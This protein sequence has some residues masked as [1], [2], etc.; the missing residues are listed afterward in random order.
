MTC[1][2]TRIEL[3]ND[4]TTSVT[5]TVEPTPDS[6]AIIYF[7]SPG[8]GID[9]QANLDS[10]GQ[11]TIS[12]SAVTADTNS[13]WDGTLQV[14][15]NSSVTVGVQVVDSSSA[16]NVGVTISDSG[17]TYCAPS[18]GGGGDPG[19]PGVEYV[20]G[21]KS[22]LAEIKQQA[23]H[24][25]FIG[26][27]IS[28]N[29]VT[30]FTTLFH[31]ALFEWRPDAWKGAWFN[32]TAGG[33][34]M[35]VSASPGS[36]TSTINRPGGGTGYSEDPDQGGDGYPPGNPYETSVYSKTRTSNTDGTHDWSIQFQYKYLSDSKVARSAGYPSTEDPEEK[37]FYARWPEGSYIFR[38]SDDDQTL[39]RSG[40][41]IRMAAQMI[42]HGISGYATEMK[43][44]L[45]Y[46]STSG[47]AVQVA[48][49]ADTDFDDGTGYWSSVISRSYDLT[50]DVARL[51]GNFG[52]LQVK[53][54]NSSGDN[55]T[56]ES[57]F[58][59][60]SDP[61]LEISY[62]G[63]GGWRTRNH[64]PG[65][66]RIEYVNNPD[67]PQEF[68]Q[69]DFW[70]YTSEALGG[71]MAA[72]GTTHAHVFIGMNDISGAEARSGADTLDSLKDMLSNMETERPGIKFVILTLYDC[73]SDV[74]N[75]R[76]QK[77]TFNDG[78]KALA[79]QRDN[80]VVVDLAGYIE[81]QFAEGLPTPQDA[82]SS[83]WLFDGVHPNQAGAAAMSSFVW[84]RVAESTGGVVSVQG[85][86]GQVILTASDFPPV[87]GSYTGMIETAADKTYT[88]DPGAVSRRS[89]TGFYI[90]SGSGTCTANL[91]VGG[92]VVST[93]SVST[94]SGD[95]TPLANTAVL[96][97]GVIT[98]VISSN[99]SA[100]DVTFSVEYAS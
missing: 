82:F 10:N 33:A 3:S 2:P 95:Q 97:D 58:W 75:Q 73:D 64:L 34:G 31:G 8:L 92:A 37:T 43:S 91:K 90:K 38:E 42:G 85:Q 14:G 25:S 61:G 57:V 40:T 62:F 76:Q 93:A 77:D 50:A 52:T 89:I 56:I 13:I 49:Y 99:S 68:S 12:V 24:V 17:V 5:F 26:D 60:T 22:I 100:T 67:T 39:G 21:D 45:Y 70:R 47:G 84:S 54:R 78:V 36:A 83:A 9:T 32:M 88:I 87:P 86:T 11:A 98:L 79:S 44:R 23:A 59:G 96:V 29:G 28:N 41:S 18:G 27:S 35:Q 46:T 81:D 65:G 16:Q 20:Y 51:E 66:Y 94:S 63:A 7:N 6:G 4:A 30:N 53:D 48:G 19:E 72:I 55:E 69:A 74:L 71:R 1:N 15:T 80:V